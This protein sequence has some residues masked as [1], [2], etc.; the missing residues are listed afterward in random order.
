[1]LMFCTL[2]ALTLLVHFLVVL[3][4]FPKIT[5]SSAGLNPIVKGQTTFR[6]GPI[7]K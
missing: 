1:M 2:F 4:H 7:F 3:S 5:Q 6:W